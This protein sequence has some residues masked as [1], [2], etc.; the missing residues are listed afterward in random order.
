VSPVKEMSLGDASGPEK[1]AGGSDRGGEGRSVTEPG[2]GN[3]RM[4]QVAAGLPPLR[5]F[6]SKRLSSF[7]A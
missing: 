6:A 4:A 1:V 2:E 3:V 7:E 5:V